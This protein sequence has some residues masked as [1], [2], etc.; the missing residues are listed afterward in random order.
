M[1][2]RLAGPPGFNLE[3]YYR[4]L[5]SPSFRAS[6]AYRRQQCAQSP[7][8]FA[9][10]YLAERHLSL[11]AGEGR[12]LHALSDLHVEMAMSAKVWMRTDLAAKECRHAWIAPRFAAKTT[13]AFL[14]LPL[15]AMAF[16]HRKYIAVWSD[17]EGQ[18]QQHLKTLRADLRDNER[19]LRDFPRLC[20]PARDGGQK[21]WD[22]AEGF[23]AGTG[24]LIQVK[25]MN[26]AALGAKFRERRPDVLLL[27][28]IEPKEG[29]YSI[30]R[31][32][33]RLV[34]L[35]DAIFPCNDQAAV[36]ITG[37]TV[38]HGSI[39]HDLIEG[40]DWGEAERIQVHHFPG[41]VEDPVTGEE[42]SCWPAKWSLEYLRNER[43]KNK[44]SYA[45]NFEN[46]PVAPDGT[47][48][49]DD[50]ITYTDKYMQWATERIMVLD[51]A[52]KS[53]KSNDETG[54]AV[55]T[56][57]ANVRKTTVERVT[58]VREKPTQLRELVHRVAVKNG[59]KLILVDV[60]NG[61]DHVLNTLMPLPPGV[62]ILPIHISK[63]SKADRF[64]DLHDLYQR[65][66]IVHAKPIPELEAQ[67]KAFPK[68]LHDDRIDAVAIGVEFFTKG[69]PGVV[70]VR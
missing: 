56:H 5:S 11:P 68:T 62:K 24:A 22:N 54:I 36:F 10:Y 40:K 12:V 6:A 2:R 29:S 21:I 37:T 15:W 23:L 35:I 13:W 27:D 9:L 51:P 70:A 31:K 28:E 4:R 39:I 43:T 17:V 58:G 30:D 59:I 64:S 69:F 52:A 45:K 67:M 44:R 19:L 50:D 60:T 1:I 55:L 16:G 25:G 3:P 18:A 7:I 65:G 47:Y 49:D 53:K 48:W 41:I 34:D 26:S 14:V 33:K 42:R 20:A 66:H 61:G 57:S 46:R 32:E 8:L 63:R 38:M